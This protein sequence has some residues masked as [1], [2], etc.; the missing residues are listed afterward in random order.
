M[1][2]VADEL[3]KLKSLL[4]AGLLTQSEFD[5]QKAAV[6]VGNA[7]KPA[8]VRKPFDFDKLAKGVMWVSGII[9]GLCLIAPLFAIQTGISLV[10][11]FCALL[12]VVSMLIR[13]RGRRVTFDKKANPIIEACVSLIAVWMSIYLQRNGIRYYEIDQTGFVWVTAFYF[14]PAIYVSILVSLER[15]ASTQ[16]L[17]VIAATS[18]IY[19]VGSEMCMSK[20]VSYL[21]YGVKDLPLWPNQLWHVMMTY[22]FLMT[23]RYHYAIHMQ[24]SPKCAAE[25]ASNDALS[26]SAERV[27][28]N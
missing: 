7:P 22:I 18:L 10:T 15:I 11:A 21:L 6:L 25:S 1:E 14:I 3:L 2:S 8:K 27:T 26:T 23:A 28:N 5:Q 12:F 16:R 20:I 19:A 9:G 24:R 17:I 4:D 13:A